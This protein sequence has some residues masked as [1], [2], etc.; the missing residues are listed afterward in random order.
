MRSS[1]V[2]GVTARPGR[3]SAHSRLRTNSTTGPLRFASASACG[4]S[5]LAE[6]KTS[7]RSPLAMASLSVP[8]A[9]NVALHLDPGGRL[10]GGDHLSQR[11]AQA[12]G[13][14]KQDGIGGTGG[15]GHG[16]HR[17]KN[18]EAAERGAQR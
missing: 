8:E 11:E 6:A 12:A 13:G 15:Y 7:A 17:C 4:C 18:C 16:C 10:V 5:M 3:T 1:S 2:A 9:P 14:V